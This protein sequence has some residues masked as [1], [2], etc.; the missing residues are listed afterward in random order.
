MD[1]LAVESVTSSQ[2][3]ANPTVL[4]EHAQDEMKVE[5][6]GTELVPKR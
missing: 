4:F 6:R 2:N 5:L 3:A 1:L